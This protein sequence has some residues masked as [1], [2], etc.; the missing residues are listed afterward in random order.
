MIQC[1][2]LLEIHPLHQRKKEVIGGSN[3][4]TLSNANFQWGNYKLRSIWSNNNPIH[5]FFNF[6]LAPIITILHPCFP[7]IAIHILH[8]HVYVNAIVTFIVCMWTFYVILYT[9][10]WSCDLVFKKR[11]VFACTKHMVKE[12]ILDYW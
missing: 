11:I 7:L 2:K 10:P 5:N 9:T 4:W 3:M 1:E 12:I 8:L 6:H